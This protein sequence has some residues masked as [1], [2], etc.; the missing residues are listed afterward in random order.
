[1]TDL[2][3]GV[4]KLNQIRMKV[5]LGTPKQSIDESRF[6]EFFSIHILLTPHIGSFL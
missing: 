2:S 1:M 4:E 6:V 3:Y 5:A